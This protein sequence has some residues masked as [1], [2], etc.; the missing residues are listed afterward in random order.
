MTDT[1]ELSKA[2]EPTEV[3]ARLYA[4]WLERDY[5]RAAA[6]SDKPA[7]SIVLPPPNVTGSLHIGHALTAT[8]QDIL[9][10]WK[11]MSGFN[12]LWLPGTDHAGIATQMVVEKELK[13]TEGKSRH[14]IGREAFLKRVW[15]W[16][17]KYGARIG[18]QHRF[19]GASLDWSR[20][21]FTMDEPSSA[22]VREV[23]VR[24]YEEGLMYRAQKLINWC[25]SCRTALSDLE[26]EH[27]EKNGSIWHI[28]Y[29]IKG[30]DR[31]LTVA[32][33]RPETMLGDTA[34]AIHPEDERYVGLAGQLVVLPLTGREI[35][36]VA[37]AELVDPKFGTG[38]VKVTPA[39]DFN[40][41]QTGLRHKLPMVSILDEAARM[42]KDTGKYAGMDRFEARKAVLADLQEQGLLE[43]E[44][45]H[46]LSIGACQRCTTVVEPR[47]SPQWFIKIE[48]LA[49]PA[50]EAV[51]QGRTKFVPEAWTNT[52]FHWMRNI[53]D[54]C[55]SRQL[56][57]GHQIPAYYCTS[58]SPRQGD[59]TDLPLDAP[60][61]K[62]GGVDFARAEPIVAR[63][64]PESCPKCG[65]KS[66]IQD[67][68]VLD[69]WFSS[70]LW[71]FSTLGW[72]RDT[73]ELKTFYPTSVMET[74]HDIIFFWVARMM[75]MGLHFMGDVPFRTVYLHAMVRDEK[76]EKMSKVKG[77]VIDPLDVILG[78]KPEQLNATLK[79]KFPQ[80]M[81]AFGAD[82]LRFTLASLT[83]QGRDIKLSM[84]RLAGYKAFC[85]KLWN[86][87]RFAL[88]NMGGYQYDGRSPKELPLT[89]ADRWIL[90]RLQ[91]ATTEASASLEVYG[92]A[93]AASTLYQFLW[94]E[95]CDW[96]I[97]LA[98]GSL[99]GED[100]AA[101]DT[102]R[103]V[104]VYA[105][106]RVLRLIHP[107]MPFITEEIWQKLPM[108]RPTE[109]IMI[110]PYPTPDTALVD[111]AA[112][113]EM[114]PVIAAI[115]GLRTIR[116]ESNLSPA[117]KVK[118]VV[119]SPD[120]RTRELLERWRGYLLPLAGLS[121]VQVGPPGP[122]PPQAAAFMATNLE[123][124]V[125]LAG[126]V[127]LDAERDRLRKEM[128]RSEQEAASILRKLENPNFVA[129]APPDVVEKDRARV[130]EL[131]ERKAKL[132]DHL[133]RIAP[134]PSMP[135]NLPTESSSTSTE[136]SASPSQPAQV[137][138]AP[139][140][141]DKGGVDLGQELKGEMGDEG[142][143][144]E[145]DPQ[146]QDALAKLREGT[147]EGLSPTD[148]H[149]L[150][151][152]YMSMGLVDDAMREFGKAKEGGDSREAP[153]KGTASKPARTGGK[154]AKPQ[155]VAASE[156]TEAPAKP[157]A[158]KAPKASSEKPTVATAAP[159]KA[160]AKKAPAKVAST[161]APAKKAPEKKA[162]AK[163]ASTKASV[164]K[165]S[166]KAAST[167]APAKKG[168]AAKAAGGKASSKKAAAVKKAAGGKASAKKGAVKKAA[169]GKASAKKGAA[170][171]AAGRASSKK[172][173]AKKAPVKKAAAKKAG[174]R[175]PA[176][177]SSAKKAAAKKV[178]RAKPS[179]RAKAR[180]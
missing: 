143:V 13:K 96:Y 56:W 106:D 65:G 151:V 133:Q 7:F 63:T 2:Y 140:K 120:A 126:L 41:Y 80:G 152:A 134:E 180:R 40:D 77:N 10:R 12:A 61:V 179:A 164:K 71:P 79:N 98:K 16:K 158:V 67:S 20:E 173:A 87:S 121:D 142:R 157:A 19:L 123:I 31:T 75:M 3:E 146:V 9:T 17:G 53:H 145:E 1:T 119:Q 174:G 165:D 35:P 154:K 39:H 113:L 155:A 114:A 42:T 85:N 135:E 23:F 73:A 18:E 74:G 69:T 160:P 86:A 46:K 26:V 32:T 8:I 92:F 62:V 128:A 153:A 66:F 122:K 78:A 147:K 38:V 15:E 60:T 76:G 139:S 28:R 101:K 148:H 11:R 4:F 105:L 51:E 6:T 127:D 112:E 168:A 171:K 84:D 109:S 138:V 89:L 91:R 117:T 37:D 48:P 24:L 178:T 99:Y 88:M 172:S 68:D 57:W 136:E 55:V 44:E 159:A 58:C 14:D 29:P 47:L 144:P 36:I 49:R 90:S 93:E 81:P 130:Q 116:G 95:L 21:R 59:D 70:A 33:T 166:A 5:F 43:K 83:Q 102:T 27:E 100:P 124:Y 45:P 72:P 111:E 132:E 52:Y 50:I 177:K 30:S 103:A 162:P 107:F 108:T 25:P 34:V 170:K 115:E 94:A 137:K 64:M 150:G 110:A 54:W 129:K 131:K 176:K 82:A 97:E 169:G 167:K 156:T 161:P 22:A 163:A 104:L 118:A 149:D 125:P 141:E 175:A